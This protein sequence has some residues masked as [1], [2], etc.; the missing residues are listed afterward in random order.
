MRRTD[1]S[2]VSIKE[3]CEKRQTAERGETTMEIKSNSE[4]RIS[5][6]IKKIEKLGMSNRYKVKV[7]ETQ[8]NLL[9]MNHKGENYIVIR[10]LGRGRYIMRK[11]IKE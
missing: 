10:N 2:G 6:N 9:D 11:V 3:E 5:I 1:I 8:A 4:K 7:L